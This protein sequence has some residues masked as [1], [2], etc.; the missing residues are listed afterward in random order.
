MSDLIDIPNCEN[1]GHAKLHTGIYMTALLDAVQRV[2][3]IPEIDIV[4]WSSNI[5]DALEDNGNDAGGGGHR[6]D[7]KQGGGKG[8]ERG[9]G[10]GPGF[11]A[12]HRTN[13]GARDDPKVDQVS[14][15][16]PDQCK[17]ERVKVH[18]SLPV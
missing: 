14:R 12:H 6:G 1:P 5:G 4:G 16:D 10:S 11:S 3:D 13:D 9:D 18:L 8:K 17:D 7:R 2:E 15:K